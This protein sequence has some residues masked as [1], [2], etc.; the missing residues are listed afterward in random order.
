MEPPPRRV[1]VHTATGSVHQVDLDQRIYTR[2]SKDGPEL[3]RDGEP[4][5]V[6]EVTI[7]KEGSRMTLLLQIRED[8]VPTLRVTGVAT[9]INWF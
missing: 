1:R 4:L 8:G 7:P 5:H 6:Y 9:K 2:W 3:R